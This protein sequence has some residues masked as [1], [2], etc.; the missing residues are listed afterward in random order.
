MD[1]PPRYRKPLRVPENKD[2]FQKVAAKLMKWRKR[3]YMVPGSVESLMNVFAVKKG[4]DDIRL[5]LDGTAS[6]LNDTLWAPWFLLPTA[7][8]HVRGLAPGYYCMDHDFGEMF[9]N[10]WL[11][12]DLRPLTGVNLTRLYPGERGVSKVLWEPWNRPCMGICP[13]PYQ[14]TRAV[15]VMKRELYRNRRDRDDPLGE[16]RAQLAW[17]GGV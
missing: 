12:R 9:Y 4:D 2:M 5:L 1:K 11:H 10:F 17:D 13:S 3:G 15:T 16:G 6:G 7:E 14:S 8:D